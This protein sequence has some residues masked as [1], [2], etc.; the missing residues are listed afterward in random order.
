[1]D[2]SIE[3]INNDD[4]TNPSTK[5]LMQALR[6]E[7]VIKTAIGRLGRMNDVA[8]AEMAERI[9]DALHAVGWSV[10]LDVYG[11]HPGE[12]HVFAIA[13]E[14]CGERGFLNLTIAGADERV[15]IEKVTA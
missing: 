15:V 5:A 4:G 6:E 8:W 1:M 11:Q 14:R 2:E 3:R 7:P 9:V 13:C 12:H 10:T